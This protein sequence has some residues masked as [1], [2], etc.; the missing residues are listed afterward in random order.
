MGA[1][2][3]APGTRT[4]RAI[5]D[6]PSTSAFKVG[7]DDQEKRCNLQNADVW[8]GVRFGVAIIDPQYE[9]WPHG[10]MIWVYEKW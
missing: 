6:Q 7:L 9:F 1:S 2:S 10:M 5:S 3:W 4:I 8:C